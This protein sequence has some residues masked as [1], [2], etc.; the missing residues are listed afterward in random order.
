MLGEG[1]MHRL[2][3]LPLRKKFQRIVWVSGGLAL[4]VAWVAFAAVSAI[5]MRADTQVR[6]DTLARV[7]A[8]N[9]QAAVAFSDVEEAHT[10][11]QSLHADSSI[12]SACIVTM[13]ERIFA[14]VVLRGDGQAGCGAVQMHSLY[15][16]KVDIEQAIMLEN[17]QLGFIRISANV[18][19]LWVELAQYL[20]AL[21]LFS[22]LSL[23]VASAIGRI[24]GYR[25]T[26]PILALADVAREVSQRR[27][28]AL[29]ARLAGRDEVGQ[30]TQSFNDML[31]QIELRDL[32]LER[33]KLTLEQQVAVRT[34]ELNEARLAAESANQAKSQFLATMSHEIRTPMNGVLGMTEL[35][36]ETSMNENQRHFAETAHA[37]GEALLSI[38]NDVLDFSKIEAGKLELECIDFSPVQVVEEV[39]ELLA[40]QAFRK[41]LEMVCDIDDSVPDAVRGDG[42]RMRQVLMNLVGNAIKFTDAGEVAVSLRAEREGETERLI[43]VVRDTG[44][45]MDAE[46]VRR[47]FMPFVQADSSH[48]RRFGGSGLGLAIVK[49]LVEMMG[50]AID[51]RSEAGEGTTFTIGLSTKVSHSVLPKPNVGRDMQGVRALVV[52]DHPANR[53]I[54]R[55]KLEHLGM[56]CAEAE[57][58]AVALKMLAQ[59]QKEGLPWQCL[60]VDLRMPVMDGIELLENAVEKGLRGDGVWIMVA[61][62][63]QTGELTRAHEAGYVQVMHKPVRRHELLR[64]LRYALGDENEDESSTN[65]E[66]QALPLAGVKVLLAEDT[67]T[68]QQV[69]MVMLGRLG[70]EVTVV[71]DGEAALAVV[72]AEKFDVVFMDCQ[73]P[74]MDGFTATRILRRQNVLSRSASYLPIIAMT[75]GVMVEDRE[76]C[77]AA[78]MD[79]FLAK[80]FRQADLGKMLRKWLPTS[81]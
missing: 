21:M 42:T 78:G 15:T 10:L 64:T 63:L 61:S 30:L 25:A 32:E 20:L 5:K 80:P 58:G 2:T 53:E 23:L 60:M 34:R 52:D 28:Y 72:A 50:G 6:L 33:H 67:P 68:N 51:V 8:F 40:E 76:A 38:I 44:I 27:D 55:R 22:V 24:L 43:V 7:S 13:D 17:E 74:E 1:D 81:H 41:S 79:D 36:L 4:L 54:L 70:C 49:Q 31:A 62:M 26:A 48:A 75:A 18:A 57:D 66:S 35:L 47:L 11:L 77:L 29:R 73:M 9:A 65:D 71:D 45:G 14:S 46:T 69:A 37:S 59:A 39:I 12:T 3:D 19:S 56:V 16:S